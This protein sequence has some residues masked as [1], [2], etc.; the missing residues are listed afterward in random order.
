[1]AGTGP[2]CVLHVLACLP[3]SQGHA[4]P[5]SSGCLLLDVEES[6]AQEGHCTHC[7]ELW[8]ALAGSYQ[9]GKV[10]PSLKAS[11]Q[12]QAATEKTL[13]MGWSISCISNPGKPV[14]NHSLA[15][16]GFHIWNSRVHAH[17]T[18]SRI[19]K[20]EELLDYRLPRSQLPWT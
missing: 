17:P 20:Q 14:S 13:P 18:N 19:S 10:L 15:R 6:H 1:M 11:S 7:S 9:Q 16:E 4:A 12:S 5:A 3:C 8:R 2:L